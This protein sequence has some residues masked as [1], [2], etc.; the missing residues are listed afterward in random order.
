MARPHRER[1]RTHLT[2]TPFD[3]PGHPYT[4]S[5]A[6]YFIKES[7]VHPHVEDFGIMTDINGVDELQYQFH[8]L[9]L[10]NETSS[11]PRFDDDCFFVSKSSQF[12]I[13][14]FSR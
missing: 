11:A 3:Y 7:E 12:L 2:C 9:Q 8:H 13:F 6:Y 1:V 14:V 10:G 5:L 4:M